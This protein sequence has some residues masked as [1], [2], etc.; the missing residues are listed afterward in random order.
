MVVTTITFDTHKFVKRLEAAGI[1]PA[2]AEALVE[3]QRD[4]LAEALDTTLATKADISSLR[5]ELNPVKTDIAVL[6]WMIGFNL[7][8]TMAILWKT[9]G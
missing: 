5:Q 4:S 1:S 7:A 6:K 3:A 8:F 9:F 2:Q